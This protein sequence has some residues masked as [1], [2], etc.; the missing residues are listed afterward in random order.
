MTEP[1]LTSAPGNEPNARRQLGADALP[2]LRA[3]RRSR[4]PAAHSLPAATV[5]AVCIAVHT[6]AAAVIY[7]DM[8]RDLYML[9]DAAPRLL[10]LE[11]GLV[12][13]TAISVFLPP[14]I[15][16]ALL[17]SVALWVGQARR[18]AE[19]ARCL[20]LAAV[21]LAAD[22]LLRAI[23][24]LLAPSPATIGELLELPSR[25]SLGPR[26]VL[27]LV[28]VRPS[29]GIA[30]WVVVCTVTAFASAWYVARA[31]AASDSLGDDL[32]VRGRRRHTETIDAV[33]AGVVVAGT[34]VALAFAGQVALPWA[35]QFVLQTFG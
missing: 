30:Y 27:D 25:F 35:T 28:D 9:F 23:G 11:R 15:P 29:A 22:G 18:A 16:T 34:W 21:P 32:S 19:V 5:I 6:L 8:V 14:I 33:R 12:R 4:N 31:L 13:L 26:M 2:G 3:R 17:A 10:V 20:S 24:V 1:T 7:R